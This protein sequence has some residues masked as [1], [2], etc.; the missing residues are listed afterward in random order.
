MC[1]QVSVLLVSDASG[2]TYLLGQKAAKSFLLWKQT[3][4]HAFHLKQI[5]KSSEFTATSV[6]DAK[7]LRLENKF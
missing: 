7:I 2:C 6:L 3:V 5:E 1:F 4:A